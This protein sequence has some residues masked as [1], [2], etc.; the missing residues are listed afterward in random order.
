MVVLCAKSFICLSLAPVER[1]FSCVS[2]RK[3]RVS[4]G[5]QKEK[6]QVSSWSKVEQEADEYIRRETLQL[7]HIICIWLSSQCFY[8]LHTTD[9]S[10]V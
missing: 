1:F 9:K 7:T 10:R 2:K 4:S 6:V 8:S 5:K 3:N